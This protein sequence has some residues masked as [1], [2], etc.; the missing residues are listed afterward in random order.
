MNLISWYDVPVLLYRN[1][2]MKKKI[3]KIVSE[4]NGG[5]RTIT[6]VNV[7]F[8]WKMKRM[9]GIE[10]SYGLLSSLS[11]SFVGTCNLSNKKKV[12]ERSRKKEGEIVINV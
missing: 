8:F 9:K 7:Y 4:H 10:K 5:E 2:Q 1:A 12:W 3:W 11:Q 6:P